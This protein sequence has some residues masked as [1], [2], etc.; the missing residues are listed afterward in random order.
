[1]VLIH[2]CLADASEAQ[3]LADGC[4]LIRAYIALSAATV[5]SSL[6]LLEVLAAVGEA[7]RGGDVPVS[8]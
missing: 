7:G 3:R 6:Q 4:A 2:N 5:G 8:Q 1:V